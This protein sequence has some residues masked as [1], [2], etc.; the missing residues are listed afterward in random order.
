M[1]IVF[2]GATVVDGTGAPGQIAD[3]G[4]A[5]GRIA[6]IGTGLTGGRVIDVDGLVLCPGF[7]DMHSHSDLRVLAEPDHLAK[8]SQGVTTEVI[9]QDGLSYAPVNDEVLAAMRAQLAGWNDDPPGFDWN[10]R[11]VGEYLDRLDRGIAVNAAYL[12]PQGTLRMLHVG[13]DDR[14]PT[15]SEMDAMKSTLDDSLTEGAFGLSSGL[16]YT[17]GMYADRANWSSCAGSSA[18][19]AL[20]QPPSPQLRG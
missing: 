14:P 7:I 12:V 13:W 1:D 2:R 20:L 15:E 9:G 10:W 17:P 5:E 19:A 3:V 4:V 11:S 6:E 18:R 8:V 16:T